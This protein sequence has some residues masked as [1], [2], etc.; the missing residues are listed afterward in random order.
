MRT[1]SAAPGGDAVVRSIMTARG[2]NS[3]RMVDISTPR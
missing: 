1:V 3:D 2:A